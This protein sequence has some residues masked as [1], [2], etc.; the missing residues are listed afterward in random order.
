MKFK[1]I[2]EEEISELKQG[3]FVNF[4]NGKVYE[5]LRFEEKYE[6]VKTFENGKFVDKINRFV[7]LNDES[8]KEI[9]FYS[10]VLSQ[11]TRESLDSSVEKCAYCGALRPQSEMK[12]ATI[13]INGGQRTSR[14][15]GDD[16]CAGHAQM[17]AEG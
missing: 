5:F 2:T 9:N 15:C 10:S 6:G 16:Y 12:S 13:W 7:F 11:A 1:K 3:D 14:Y 8:R 17:A 4:G